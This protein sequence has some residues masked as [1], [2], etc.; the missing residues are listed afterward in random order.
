LLRPTTFS[1]FHLMGWSQLTVQYFILPSFNK[2]NCNV[3]PETQ[4]DDIWGV[5]ITEP[6]DNSSQIPIPSY[7][8]TGYCPPTDDTAQQLDG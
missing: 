7:P 8:L 2:S 4:E 5:S 6:A 1:F 3:I